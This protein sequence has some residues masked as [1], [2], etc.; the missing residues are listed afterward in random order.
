MQAVERQSCSWR[1][2]EFFGR[3]LDEP[4]RTAAGQARCLSSR[5]LEDPFPLGKPGFHLDG[6]CLETVGRP[7]AVHQLSGAVQ[8]VPSPVDSSRVHAEGRE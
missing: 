1:N 3:A 2:A 8:P 6:R 5:L 4:R 7:L